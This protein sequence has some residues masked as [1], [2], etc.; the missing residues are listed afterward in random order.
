MEY[1][2]Y[3]TALRATEPEL[4]AEIAGFHGMESVLR[5]MNARGLP[6]A[7]MDLVT[8]DEFAHD[9]LIPLD[10]SGRHLVFGVT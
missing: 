10:G 9:V 3:V 5:W 8:Q 4:A 6:L 1:G 7:G 2:D